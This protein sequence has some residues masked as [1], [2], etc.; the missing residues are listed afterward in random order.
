[1]GIP[2][3]GA[4]YMFGDNESVVKS[5][6]IPESNIKKKHTANAYHYVREAITAGL[7]KFIHIK[8][9]RNPADVLT[10]NNP[11]SIWWDLLKPLLHWINP[12]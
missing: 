2:I 8:G 6:T 3:D 10:K 1:M 9:K 5:S 12:S 7:I 11:H 4:S